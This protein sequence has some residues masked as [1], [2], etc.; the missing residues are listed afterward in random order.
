LNKVELHRAGKLEQRCPA[1]GRTEAA[2][3]YC[4]AC[5]R[6]MTEADWH[7]PK[8]TENQQK[9]LRAAREAIQAPALAEIGQAPLWEDS[10]A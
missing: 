10:A 9:A 7:R 5:F 6:P 4:T 1:C 2:G 8:A 3:A